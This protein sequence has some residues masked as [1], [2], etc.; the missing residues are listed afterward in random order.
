[1]ALAH[2]VRVDANGTVL[3]A[4][5]DDFRENVGG[6]VIP[7]DGNRLTNVPLRAA[8]AWL[9]WDVAGQQARSGLRF[10]G[11]RSTS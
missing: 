2:G 11:A 6:V 7:R 1:M 8:N 4:K 5:Y 9:S 10:V 3:K